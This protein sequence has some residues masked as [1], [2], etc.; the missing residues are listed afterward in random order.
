MIYL[1]FLTLLVV[2]GRITTDFDYSNSFYVFFI[3]PVGCCAAGGR[4]VRDALIVEHGLGW[5]SSKS[6]VRTSKAVRF[7]LAAEQ[8]HARDQPARR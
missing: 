2:L 7:D 6:A 5:H 1:S 3:L 4:A 8:M